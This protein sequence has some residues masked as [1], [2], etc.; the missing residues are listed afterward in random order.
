MIDANLKAYATPRQ[1]EYIDAVNTYGDFS[2]TSRAMGVPRS[3]IQDGISLLKKKA[4]RQG[5]SPE[6]DMQ[7]TIPDGFLVKGV[8]TY[9]N[10]DGKPSAQWVKSSIDRDRQE[11]IMREA[12]DA[13]A[14][15]LPRLPKQPKSVKAT[16]KD[17]CNV[18]TLTDSHVGALCWKQEGG[19]DWDLKIAEEILT[20]CFQKMVDASPAA[21]TAVVAQLGDFLHQDSIV[22]VT[23]SHGHILDADSRYSKIIK[24]A[25]RIL[26]R[27]IDMAL[28][29][30]YKVVVLLAEGN[31][32]ISSSIWMRTMFAA[33]Y[34]NEPRICV[35][36]TALP[37]YVYQHGETMLSWHH[38]HLKNIDQLPL[39]FAAQF[40]VIWGTTKKRYCHTGHRH[41]VEEKEFS[42]MKVLQHSTLAA[43]DAHA[44]RGGWISER[45]VSAITYHKS[46]GQ[47]S[48]VTITPE[49][50]HAA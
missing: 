47:Y 19:A 45:E 48:R 29:R 32:D 39:L 33:L 50:L 24:V 14:S 1:A 17:L 23:P 28:E 34:E 42:G 12:F 31:H 21:G 5:Y 43:R 16:N 41:H 9:Y 22:P 18:F 11:Q 37:Y 20:G 10:K 36:D 15:E 4:A 49:M 35:I 13:M 38:G 30:H 3:T 40:P 27:V 2:K 6:H 25:I 7:R 26:R 8:S 44:A 46:F